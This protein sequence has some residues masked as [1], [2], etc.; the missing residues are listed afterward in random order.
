MLFDSLIHGDIS[1]H[2]GWCLHVLIKCSKEE[3]V[4]KNTIHTDSH[5]RINT[6]E[7][8]P[9]YFWASRFKNK[10]LYKSQHLLDA[11]LSMLY[12]SRCISHRS[13]T[14]DFLLQ[15]M[16]PR[17]RASE[18]GELS[19]TDGIP[20]N[21]WAGVAA[22]CRQNHWTC[23]PGFTNAQNR[24][25][26]GNCVINEWRTLAVSG[27]GRLQCRRLVGICFL[28]QFAAYLLFTPLPDETGP[29]SR[30]FKLESSS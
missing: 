27:G 26:P 19:R 16:Q 12:I 24:K 10:L 22:T 4:N 8:L 15:T 13:T 21:C 25:S 3:R 5:A 28:R 11:V 7:T 29:S 18:S 6:S 20:A 17:M 23:L 9:W 1:G 14:F 2:T 30:C